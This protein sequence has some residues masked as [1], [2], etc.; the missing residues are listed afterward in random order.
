M[1][2]IGIS[3]SGKTKYTN[4]ELINL[5]PDSVII[6][7]D[8]TRQ[9][10]AAYRLSVP[11]YYADKS[12]FL[13]NEKLISIFNLHLVRFA[14]QRGKTIIIDNTN[15]NKHYIKTLLEE[16]QQHDDYKPEYHVMKLSENLT[17]C[18]RN[19]ADRDGLIN[20]ELDYINKQQENY[21]QFKEI[22]L[23]N[24]PNVIYV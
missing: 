15:L 1:F 6:S 19:V 24:E 20:E 8:L 13:E 3:G 9:F 11:N 5:Y 22:F 17:Q 18:R 4:E 7:R 21:Y 16:A 2:L 10:L 14:S 23:D 12:S